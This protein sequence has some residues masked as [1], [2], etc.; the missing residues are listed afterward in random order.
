[1]N[2]DPK[3]L[4][5]NLRKIVQEAEEVLSH[6]RDAVDE[7]DVEE[8]K[9]RL[10]DGLERLRDR[11]DEMG[12]RLKARFAD[13]EDRIESC[14]EDL[15][16]RVRD[17]VEQTQDALRSRPFR[18]VGWSFLAGMVIGALIRGRR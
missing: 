17:R 12:D 1:M 18:T 5:K 8:V 16:D 6:E 13:I 15:E 7:A 14:Y 9:H 11:Y 2:A 10:Q 4:M 3:N